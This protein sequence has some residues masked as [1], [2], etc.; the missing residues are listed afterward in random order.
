[1]IAVRDG[2]RLYT[3]IYA[4]VD[5]LP[6]PVVLLRTPY[7]LSPYGKGFAKSLRGAESVLVRHRYI[8]VYQ[9]VRGT[10]RSE[11]DF[12]NLRPLARAGSGECDEATDTFD[13][14]EW[15]LE[16]CHTNG[17]VGVK[18]ISYPGFYATLAALSG[19]PAVKA[20]SP[21]APVTDWFKGDDAHI[22][23]AFQYAMYGFASAFFRQR[24]GPGI[25]FPKPLVGVDGDVYDWFLAQDG[26]GGALDRFDGRLDFID[27]LRAHPRYDR[28]WQE[29]DPTRHLS[30][31]LPAFLVV[32]GWYDGEDCFGCFETWRKLRARAP[33][34]PAHL[35][36]GP[37]YH[38][39]WKK[40][41]F[42]H[43]ADAWFGSGSAQH[44]MERIEYPFFAY[45]LEG[46]GERPAAVSI[47][48]SA[49]TMRPVMEG[50]DS[51]SAWE[52]L[53]AWP[54]EDVRCSLLHLTDLGS[55]SFDAPA[56]F[57]P[58]RYE[59]DPR[60]PVPFCAETACWS[61]DAFAADQRFAARR[62]DVLS[63]KTPVLVERVCAEGPLELH[64]DVSLDTSDADLV[65]KLLDIRPDG[66]QLP[67]R[68]G[69]LP[70]RFR[71]GLSNPEAAVPQ[72][73]MRISIP[74]NDIGHH[75]LPGHRIGVQLQSSC[76][77]LIAMNP[78]RFL[79][80]PYAAKASDA[81]KAEITVYGGAVALPV[82]TS[83]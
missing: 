74:M 22:N 50:R 37:W 72:Q 11:G 27:T 79:A 51:S 15:I 63:W 48:P 80:D 21:Q 16:N 24:K 59:S 53:S 25:R 66:Y 81:V 1:M 31:V 34:T 9:N 65:V 36:A 58:L 47:L 20:V 55:L 60:K 46:K 70:V 52:T 12:V 69:V 62:T 17:C 56:C 76:F 39:G 14:V 8:I 41:R 61:R 40:Q 78:Q 38:G 77:P 82:R 67:V 19:H 6:H 73:R 4:P 68:I 13:T 57:T 42:D 30:G 83:L 26:L 35:C 44:F 71:G 43:L 33:H 23:G 32:G 28:F 5:D 2:V 3:A 7:A 75:F 64:L 18:G 49:E 10:F 29:A 54:A 45:Y